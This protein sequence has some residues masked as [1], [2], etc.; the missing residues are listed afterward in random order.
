[1]L[2]F[3][4]FPLVS[5]VLCLTFIFYIEIKLIRKT[6]RCKVDFASQKEDFAAR[7]A[8]RY[9]LPETLPHRP[10]W[11]RH[12]GGPPFRSI[13]VIITLTLTLS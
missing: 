7:F 3:S 8:M 11:V 2:P 10:I 9:R 13:T 6:L 12:S 4:S 1:M 5:I